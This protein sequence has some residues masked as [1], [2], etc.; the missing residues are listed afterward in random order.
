[1][2]TLKKSLAL[3]LALVMVL[4]LGVVGASA[5]NKL[6]SYTDAGEIGDAYVEA[7]GVLT[8]L[9]SSMAA[10]TPRSSPRHLQPC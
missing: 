4:G 6:D 7:V 5:D 10:P 3:V 1:M 2:R 8:G 9:A